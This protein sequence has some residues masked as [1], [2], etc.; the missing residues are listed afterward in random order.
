MFVF[1][2]NDLKSKRR[3]RNMQALH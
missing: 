2:N 3:D 1:K